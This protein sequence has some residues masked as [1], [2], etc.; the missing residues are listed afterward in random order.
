MN[1][2]PFYLKGVCYSPTPISYATFTPQIGDWFYDKCAVLWRSEHPDDRGDL[3]TMRGLGINHL[4][5]YFWWRWQWPENSI[6]WVL[7]KGWKAADAATFDHTP[8]LDECARNGIYVMIGL[9]VNSGD[10]FDGPAKNRACFLEL[11]TDTAAEIGRVYG[12]HPAVI[13]LCV[14]NEQN[15]PGR[16]SRPD[17]WAGLAAMSAAFKANAPDKVTMVAFQNDAE[18]FDTVV[19]GVPLPKLYKQSFDLYGLN[20]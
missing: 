9:A 12:K 2:A 18:V 8:F 13:G 15:Q 7:K 10:I 11:Y 6:D 20:I 5:T 17:F 14:G 4:R 16:N 19:D 3:K 1:G